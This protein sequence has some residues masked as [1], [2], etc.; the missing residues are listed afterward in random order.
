MRADFVEDP[1]A[2]R[3]VESLRIMMIAGAKS[4][5]MATG[6]ETNTNYETKSAITRRELERYTY[7]ELDHM[8]RM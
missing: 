2:R 4:N 3:I 5:M 1:E 6:M 7:Q 8:A